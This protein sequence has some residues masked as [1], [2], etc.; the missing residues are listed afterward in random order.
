MGEDDTGAEDQMVMVE[1][2]LDLCK[3]FHC[4]PGSRVRHQSQMTEL[5]DESWDGRTPRLVGF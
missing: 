3:R 4:A 5:E 1:V 2:Q